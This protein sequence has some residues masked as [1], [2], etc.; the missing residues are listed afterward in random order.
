MKIVIP[1][2]ARLQNIEAFVKKIEEPD[3]PGLEIEFPTGYFV[4][5][6]LVVAAVAA[7]GLAARQRGE[8]VTLGPAPASGGTAYLAR[9]GLFDLLGVDSPV[10]VTEH[11][12]TGRFIPLQV[13]RTPAE[14]TRFI[15][16]LV[17]VLH[18]EPARA[19]AIQYALAELVRNTLEHSGGASAVVTAQLYKTG[20]LALGVADCGRGIRESLQESYLVT[21]DLEAV[22]LAL[23]PGV[24]G[25]TSNPGGTFD[26]A[27][28]GLFF[29]K[30]MAYTSRQN[31]VLASGEGLF[32]LRVKRAPGATEFTIYGDPELDHATRH[33]DLP[34]WPGTLVGL[35]ITI[36]DF[37]EFNAFLRFMREAY[38]VDVKA[39]K[40]AK[41]KKEARFR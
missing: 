40:K 10:E 23:T 7:A 30:G 38:D 15:Q 24:T 32:K 36:D 27:G 25:T 29:C 35:D 14:Q 4:I 17:P 18:A 3:E 21:G 19:A 33:D 16:D 8:Q 39:K 22:Q 12:E 6:P 37:Q 28:A 31:M 9:M 34:G 11:E 26:N 5:H 41:Y 2:F 20:V 13:I 1:Q